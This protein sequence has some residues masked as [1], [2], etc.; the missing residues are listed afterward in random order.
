M[1]S[2]LT[3]R[4]QTVVCEGAT[5]SA[6]PVTSRVPQ[7]TVLG[8]LLPPIYINDLPNGLT[9]SVKLFADNTLLYGMVVDD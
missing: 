7:G 5:S 6:P 4:V 9:S 8:P 2:F 1:E 3:N